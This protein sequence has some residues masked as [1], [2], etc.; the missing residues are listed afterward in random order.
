[1][2]TKKVTV[3]PVV[4]QAAG[5]RIHTLLQTDRNLFNQNLVRGH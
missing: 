3:P 5:G 2:W 1:M 4:R